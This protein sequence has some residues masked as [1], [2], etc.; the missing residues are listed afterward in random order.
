M[1]KSTQVMSV[2]MS[3]VVLLLTPGYSFAERIILGINNGDERVRRFNDMTGAYVGD[4]TAL[5]DANGPYNTNTDLAFDGD[6]IYTINGL[7][8]L[9]GAPD[10]RVRKFDLNGNFVGDAFQLREQNGTPVAQAQI[11]IGTDGQ[12]FYSLAA[13]DTRVRKYNTAGVFLGDVFQLREQDG[14]PVIQPQSA[15]DTDGV[16]FYTVAAND[17]RVRRFSLSGVFI[18]DDINLDR[19]SFPNMYANTGI[20]VYQVPVTVPEANS[21]AFALPTLG[22]VVL[23]NRVGG[24][25]VKRRKK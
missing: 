7:G 13:N 1:K 17:P 2:A 9:N 20:A 21:L 6:F 18:G 12:F 10:Q 25:V 11:G 24:T 5:R 3:A 22:M 14:S 16:F 19:V 4:F 15:I 8:I 23:R